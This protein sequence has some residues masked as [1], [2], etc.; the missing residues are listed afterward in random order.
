MISY[1]TLT[2]QTD[3]YYFP[4]FVALSNTF[5]FTFSTT[6]I[7][8][9]AN[10]FVFCDITSSCTNCDFLFSNSFSIEVI[11]GCT[12]TISGISSSY[13]RI[14]KSS[15]LPYTVISS[16]YASTTNSPPCYL[17][18]TLYNSVGLLYSGTSPLSFD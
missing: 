13:S 2:R 12:A 5:T 18:Y 4:Y 6:S 15:S 10:Y 3:G 16:G 9:A 11:G 1:C 17:T 8:A 14:I 7:L